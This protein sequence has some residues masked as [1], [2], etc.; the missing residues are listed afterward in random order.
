MVISLIGSI[1]H[2]HATK[3]VLVSHGGGRLPV[4]AVGTA[5]QRFREIPFPCWLLI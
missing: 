5:D 1:N 3:Y 2:L 4:G